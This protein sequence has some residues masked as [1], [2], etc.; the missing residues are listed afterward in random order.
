MGFLQALAN[1]LPDYT[2][3]LPG[4]TFYFLDT[5]NTALGYNLRKKFFWKNDDLPVD[6][7]EKVS[8][9]AL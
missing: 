1:R 8:F 6:L 7:K 5:T 9:L 4:T 3:S 2:Y